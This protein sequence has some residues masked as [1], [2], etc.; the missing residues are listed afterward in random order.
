MV[1]AMAKTYIVK[2]GG[3]LITDK[4][5]PRHINQDVLEQVSRELVDAYKEQSTATWIIGNGAG[6]FGHYTVQA[7]KYK[8]EPDDPKRIDAVRQ[9]VIDLNLSVVK[10]LRESGLPAT[11]ISPHSFM[12]YVDG[13]LVM[14]IEPL[15]SIW[16]RGEVPIVHGDV[17]GSSKTTRIASTEDVLEAIGLHMKASDGKKAEACVYSSSVAGVLDRSGKTIPILRSS[18]DLHVHQNNKDYDVTGGM[19]Q[20][21]AAGF[22]ALDY[23]ERVF[24]VNGAVKGHIKNALRLQKVDSELVL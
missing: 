20:K 21:V 11:G 7:V 18:D 13:Q 1:T 4:S 9:S 6:S 15:T 3:G 5:I 17:I 23:A 12:K 14:D 22:R 8:D 10:A 19:A 24:I 16:S 2:L